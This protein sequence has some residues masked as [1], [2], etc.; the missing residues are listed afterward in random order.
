M[1]REK[2][3][4]SPTCR[5]IEQA[6]TRTHTHRHTVGHL[7]LSSLGTKPSNNDHELVGRVAEAATTSGNLTKLPPGLGRGRGSSCPVRGH[8]QVG[9]EALQTDKVSSS[10]KDAS[11]SLGSRGGGPRDSQ[12]LCLK[13]RRPSPGTGNK[14]GWTQ[15]G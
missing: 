10:S 5:V 12:C 6:R 7:L 3:A 11:K 1:E 15:S 2:S 13:T 9:G 4:I 8:P 14:K